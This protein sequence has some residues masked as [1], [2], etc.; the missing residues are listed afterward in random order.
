MLI[1]SLLA[2]HHSLL[3]AYPRDFEAAFGEEMQAVFGEALEQA[4]RAGSG[5]AALCLAREVAHLP[6]LLLAAHWRGWQTQRPARLATGA[7]YGKANMPI[8][9]KSRALVGVVLISWAFGLWLLAVLWL[10]R[11]RAS[12]GSLL[13]IMLMALPV[14][15]LLGWAMVP[16]VSRLGRGYWLAAGLLCLAG[17]AWPT[18]LLIDSS[19]SR[20]PW[21]IGAVLFILPAAA[22]LTAALLLRAALAGS[23]GRRWARAACAVLAAG[24]VARTMVNLYWLLVW[25]ST[26]D[27]LGVLWLILPVLAAFTSGSVLAASLSGRARWAAAYGLLVP[28]LVAAVAAGAQRVDFRELTGVRAERVS[29]ALAA[30]HAREGRYPLELRQL[31]PRDLLRVPGPVIIDG[32]DWCYASSGDGYQLGYVDRDHWSSPILVGRLASARGPAPAEPLCAAE[33]AALEPAR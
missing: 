5:P 20:I 11:A 14:A 1:R 30:Y 29:Q 16:I 3:R 15:G 18:A 22:V 33:I 25:D 6:G 24:L 8:E 27:P 21:P 4:A 2:L 28:A 9:R 23:G 31:T 10:G 7:G 26:Y 12:A 19:G 13:P 17:L 32:Q